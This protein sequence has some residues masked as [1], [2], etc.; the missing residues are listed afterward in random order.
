MWWR[1]RCAGGFRCEEAISGRPQAWRVTRGP[2]G[3]TAG[4]RNDTPAI[5][6]TLSLLVS[7][8]LSVTLFLLLDL[9]PGTHCHIRTGAV[10]TGT[11]VQITDGKAPR[12]RG[13]EEQHRPVGR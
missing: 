6:I 2:A 13:A 9:R 11:D 10:A 3:S 5:A 4:A 8:V 1:Q 7:L 12:P